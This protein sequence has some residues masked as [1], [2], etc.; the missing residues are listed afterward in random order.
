MRSGERRRR[1]RSRGRRRTG[2]FGSP[3][4]LRQ[5]NRT[6]EKTAAGYLGRALHALGRA[7]ATAIPEPK[8]A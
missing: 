1:A 3:E 8:A 4:N 5:R 7:I 2:A 6:R